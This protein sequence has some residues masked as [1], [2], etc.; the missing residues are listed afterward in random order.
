MHVTG[1]CQCPFDVSHISLRKTVAS[2]IVRG[3]RHRRNPPGICK[4]LECLTCV[5]RTIVRQNLVR[6]TEHRTALAQFISQTTAG[7]GYCHFVDQRVLAISV[8][9]LIASNVGRGF[10]TGVLRCVATVW[11]ADSEVTMVHSCSRLVALDNFRMI[12][13]CSLYQS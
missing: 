6:P 10:G 2:S 4:C 11:R 12:C 7:D 3:E 5:L 1:I 13:T 8:P 9:S